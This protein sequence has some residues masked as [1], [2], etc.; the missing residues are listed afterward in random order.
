M[1]FCWGCGD[2]RA[3]REENRSLNG[4]ERRCGGVLLNKCFFHILCLPFIKRFGRKVS[5][6][7]HFC[8]S[9]SLGSEKVTIVSQTLST[10]WR[11]CHCIVI[12]FM[13]WDDRVFLEVFCA[14]NHG[15]ILMVFQIKRLNGSSALWNPQFPVTK[16]LWL[17][18]A[19]LRQLV[20]VK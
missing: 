5:S 14:L 6:G 12:A 8:V 16:T 2:L 7:S 19:Q 13:H 17:C 10:G 3:S 11:A 20:F 9:R 4:R 18:K 15:R 1:G